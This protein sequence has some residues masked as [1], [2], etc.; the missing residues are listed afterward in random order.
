MTT[1]LSTQLLVRTTTVLL[2]LVIMQSSTHGCGGYSTPTPM[3]Q[4]DIYP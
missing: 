2:L 4:L 1:V 3:P